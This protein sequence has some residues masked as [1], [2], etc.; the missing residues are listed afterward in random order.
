MRGNDVRESTEPFQ[1]LL[2]L[3]ASSL[4]PLCPLSISELSTWGFEPPHVPPTAL[5][6]EP[7]S[8]GAW[9]RRGLTRRQRALAQRLYSLGE[10]CDRGQVTPP[11]LSSSTSFVKGSDRSF[12]GAFVRIEDC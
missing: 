7:V 9:L 11:L 10:L 3:T 5:F 1:P 12:T 8:H 2:S 4:D 6:G